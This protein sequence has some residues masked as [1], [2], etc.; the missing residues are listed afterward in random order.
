MKVRGI[1]FSPAHWAPKQGKECGRPIVDS[2]DRSAKTPVLNGPNVAAEAKER[3]GEI[4][5]PTIV[6]VVNMVLE[7]KD[8]Q[9]DVGWEDIELWKMDL[10]GAFTL[11][12][13]KAENS[14]LFAVELG[15]RWH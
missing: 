3:W 15:G 10:K 9:F 7:F 12:S 8:E 1:H 4:E 13:F 14:Q 11:M 5:N 6:E 2:S